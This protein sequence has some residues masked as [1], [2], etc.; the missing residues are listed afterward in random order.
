MKKRTKLTGIAAGAAILVLGACYTVF[1]AP[2]LDQE[3]WV[4]IESAVERGSLTVGVTESGSLDY[5][6]TS[7][8]YDLDLT[9]TESDDDDDDDDDE[10]E[11][12]TVQKY[13][14][15]D[16][17]F[18]ATGQRIQEGDALVSFTEESVESVR[19]LLQSAL[20][21]A[22]ASYNEA[23]SEYNLAVLEAETD[24]ETRMIA[25]KYAGE[26]YV[27]AGS[28]ID[29]EIASLQIEIQQRTANIAK[30]E[31]KVAQAQEDYSD[32]LET[33]GNAKATMDIVDTSNT[34]NF[35]AI[36]AEYLNAQ[37][38]LRNAE[39]ALTQARENLENNASQL[40][41]LQLTLTDAQ[42]KRSIDKL[43]ATENYQESVINGENAQVTYDA[44]IESLKEELLEEE[45]EKQKIE[46]QLEAFE[47]FVGE[48]GILYADGSGIITEVGYEAGDRLT[49]TGI[50]VAYATPG[51]MTIPVDVT[52]EDVVSMDVGNTVEIV[53]SAYPDVVYEGTI[54]SIDTTA[55]S[56]SSATISYAVVI[57]VEGDTEALY[58]GMTADITFVTEEKEDTLYISR[59]AIVE[60]NDKT[61][62]YVKTAL[63]GREL[64]EVETGLKNST[65]IE[66]LS[67]LEEG[68]II[69]IASRVSS[70]DEIEETADEGTV[71]NDVTAVDGSMMSDLEDNAMSGVDGNGMSGFEGGM[72]DFEGGGMDQS[73]AQGRE[74]RP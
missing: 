7:I 56:R 30:L 33:Y 60:E 24:Y 45:E 54:L 3:Q 16:E 11:E 18:V 57:G 36:Q 29:D 5:G 40:E 20:V 38:Q 71:Q 39:N 28:S 72:P 68:D 64:K 1:I 74:V 25:Q 8:L 51:D 52:Q 13:L 4:Y 35:M 43:N 9:V 53:F 26:I 66:I 15:V 55:T 32:A 44:K 48:D 37:T 63:G 58:G 47:A 21:D 27:N 59:K 61:Y 62:V 49:D 10:E 41:S 67:G 46:E 70:E 50:V 34:V 14:K 23:E 42:A 22:K 73:G 19:K 69:Y 2:R 12:E 6:I 65:S 17:V 31:E